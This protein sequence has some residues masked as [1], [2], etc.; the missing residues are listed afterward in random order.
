MSHEIPD[1]HDAD[2]VLKLYDLRREE[3]L[4]RSREAVNQK[5]W[6]K[7]PDELLAIMR[8]DHE[9]NTAFRQV[10]AYWEMVYGMARHGIVNAEFLMENNGEGLFVFAKVQPW[11]TELREASGPRAFANAEWIATRTEMGRQIFA[12]TRARIAKTLES[13]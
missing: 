7:G 13:K 1:Y 9:L 3:L 8:P 2:L 11:I 5:F 4:R 10:A 12:R 6:P